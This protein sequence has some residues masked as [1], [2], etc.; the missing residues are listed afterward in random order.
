MVGDAVN[1]DPLQLNKIMTRIGLNINFS[2]LADVD[3]DLDTHLQ[4]ICR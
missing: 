4:R 1:F 2:T 3:A